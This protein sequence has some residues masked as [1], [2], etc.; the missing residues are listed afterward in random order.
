MNKNDRK[1]IGNYISSLEDIK[2]NIESVL[3]E[4]G[5]QVYE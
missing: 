5:E 1:Q 3:D 4:D 2:Q